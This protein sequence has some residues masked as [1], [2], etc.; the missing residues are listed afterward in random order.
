MST[1]TILHLATGHQLFDTRIFKKMAKAHHKMGFDVI[2]I[3]PDAKGPRSFSKDGIQFKTV[4]PFTNGADRYLNST[5]NVWKS[6][7]E[8]DKSTTTIQFHDYDL[9][10]HM[11]WASIRGWNVIYD[12]HE[13]MPRLIK[14]QPWLPGWLKPIFSLVLSVL[15]WIGGKLFNHIITATE[16]IAARFPIQKTTVIKNYPKLPDSAKQHNSSAAQVPEKNGILYVGGITK[17]KGLWE[18]IEAVQN[19]NTLQ[20]SQMILHLVGPFFPSSLQKEVEVRSFDCVKMHGWLDSDEFQML[21]ETCFCGMVLLHY[22]PQYNEALPTKLYEYMQMGLPAICSKTPPMTEIIERYTCGFLFDPDETAS[23]GNQV[24]E[25]YNKPDLIAELGENGLKAIVQDLN[26]QN[27]E[28]M[29]KI[30]FER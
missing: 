3:M 9:L 19:A 13:D 21:A 1:K 2:V 5:R 15:E 24:S 10:P 29:L 28:K 4:S 8:F 11:I 30:I 23:I 18:M 6:V 7:K 26:W 16:V 25:L 17:S 14:I 22:L 20:E 27:E 12:A